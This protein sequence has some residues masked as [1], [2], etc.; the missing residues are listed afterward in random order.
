MV[1][2]LYR[3]PTARVCGAAVGVTPMEFH[4]DLWCKKTRVHRLSYGIVAMSFRQNTVLW[5]INGKADGFWTTACIL[6]TASSGKR[7]GKKNQ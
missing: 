5:R 2:E 4:Q 7:Q 6:S 3:F 1:P